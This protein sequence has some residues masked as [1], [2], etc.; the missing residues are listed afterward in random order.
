[1]TLRCDI[2]IPWRADGAQRDG[3]QLR[4]RAHRMLTELV[5]EHPLPVAE[6]RGTPEARLRAALAAVGASCP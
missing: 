4:D 1:V 2:D 3:P 6:V 5:A